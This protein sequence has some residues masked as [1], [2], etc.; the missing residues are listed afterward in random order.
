MTE[1]EV[2]LCNGGCKYKNILIPSG[3][4][5]CCISEMAN[6]RNRKNKN[7]ELVEV[8][9]EVRVVRIITNGVEM[10]YCHECASKLLGFVAS[11]K[12]YCMTEREKFESG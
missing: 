1:R 2:P 12:E 6:I 4:D 8:S 7:G 11:K 5:R 9:S 3:I 10:N